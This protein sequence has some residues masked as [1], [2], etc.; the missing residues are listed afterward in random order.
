VVNCKT[1]DVEWVNVYEN[2][3]YLY[4]LSAV[5]EIGGTTTIDITYYLDLGGAGLTDFFLILGRSAATI[6]GRS[7]AGGSGRVISVN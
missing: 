6:R 1:E 3:S 7:I 4:K 5:P 2:G